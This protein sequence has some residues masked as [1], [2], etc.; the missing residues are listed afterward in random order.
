[1]TIGILQC[2]DPPAALRAEYGSY[3]VMMQKLLG[4]AR[5]MAIYNV[6]AVALPASLTAY[7]AYVLTGS[8]VG[9][10][11]DLPWIHGLVHFLQNSKGQ[12]K[13]ASTQH[14]CHEPPLRIS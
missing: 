5:N 9:V 8:P 3:G 4:P 7:E 2:G 13:L 12:A 14:F 10:Y 1:M 11:E 6:A